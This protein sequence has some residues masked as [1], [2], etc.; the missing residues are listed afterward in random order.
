MK[1]IQKL[2]LLLS[3]MVCSSL[4]INGSYSD[5]DSDTERTMK[6]SSSYKSRGSSSSLKS[7]ASS[8]VNIHFNEDQTGI[9]F[10]IEKPTVAWKTKTFA[11]PVVVQGRPFYD[12]AGKARLQITKVPSSIYANYMP[13]VAYKDFIECDGPI[14]EVS[15][16]EY[17]ELVQ[18]YAPD[19]YKKLQQQ[20]ALHVGRY[21]RTVI[22][23]VEF[24]NL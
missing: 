3:F 14:G 16:D 6:S 8:P 12:D 9:S 19:H 2:T 7:T 23:D 18:Q 24:N 21:K 13:E 10:F 5:D 22:D 11:K 17:K 4:S 20:A 15:M 1:N